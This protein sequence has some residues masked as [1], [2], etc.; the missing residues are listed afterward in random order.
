MQF[1]PSQ[2]AVVLGCGSWGTALGITLA[3][4]F[5]TVTLVGRDDDQVAEIN[6][7]HTNANFLPRITLPTNIQATTDYA[8]T[9]DASLILFVVPTSATRAAATELAKVG[10]PST[11]PLISCSK[12]IERGSGSRMSEIIAELLPQNPVAVHSGPTHAEEVSTKMATCAV[13]GT[14][15]EQLAEELQKVFTTP[16]FRTYTSDDVAG[17][18]LGGALKNVFAIAAGVISGIGLG[19]NA[20]AAMVTRGL[21]EMTRLGVALGGRPETFAGLSGV[22]DLM[23]TCYSSHS[24]NNRV[25]KAIGSGETLEEVTTRLGMV[26]EGVP[27]TLSIYEAAKAHNIDTPIID[28]VYHILYENKSAEEALVELLTRDLKPEME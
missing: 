27:N 28:A 5:H 10:I 18:E 7:F 14:P 4:Y 8:V 17:I 1:D 20:I 23:V 22:G 26:A 6:A 13:V 19:D 16:F 12:G 9:K 24:R 15:D 2:S 3:E 25:G 21:A 11:I